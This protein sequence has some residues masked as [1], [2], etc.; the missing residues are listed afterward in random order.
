[1]ARYVAS[2][3]RVVNANQFKGLPPSLRGNHGVAIPMPTAELLVIESAA[4]GNNLYRYTTL[5]EFAGDTWHA[6]LEDAYHRN[7][8]DWHFEREG[9]KRES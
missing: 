3:K 5:G 9:Q 7:N 8:S 4:E 6:S 1:M 2:V